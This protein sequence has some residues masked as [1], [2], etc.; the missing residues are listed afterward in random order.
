M[1]KTSNRNTALEDSM[2]LAILFKLTGNAVN[3]AK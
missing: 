3:F 2:M 1:V